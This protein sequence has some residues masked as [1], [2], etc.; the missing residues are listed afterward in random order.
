MRRNETSPQQPP[1]RRMRGRR[2][3]M[4]V[5]F[6]IAGLA[7]CMPDAPTSVT[8]I[9]QIEETLARKTG[10]MQLN[11]VLPAMGPV[12]EET[13]VLLRGTG[14]TDGM[15]VHFGDQEAAAVQVID[16]NRATAQVPQNG[17]GAVDV[18]IAGDHG[19]AVAPDGFTWFL[20]GPEDGTDTDGDGLTD[21]QELKGWTIKV[22]VLGWGLDSGHVTNVSIPTPIWADTPSGDIVVVYTARSDI[23]NPDT[24]GDG[25]GDLDEF[26]VRADPVLRDT[27]S[28]GLWDG[29]E[30]FRW[31]TSPVS[32]DT[33]GDARSPDVS[34]TFATLPPNPSLFD[35]AELY[36]SSQLALEP[37]ARGQIKLNATSPTLDDTDGDSVRDTDEIDT[38][39]RVPWLADMPQLRFEIVDDIDVRLDVEYA[40]EVGTTTAFETS[41]AIGQSRTLSQ[42]QSNTVS[43]SVTVGGEVNFS[44]TELGGSA[45]VE[46]TAGFEQ[47]FETTRESSISAERTFTELQE[48]SRTNTET[49]ATGSINTGVRISN[50]G[51]I[52][53]QLIDM[54]H[55][56]RQWQPNPN[57][58]LVDM[59]PGSY[60]TLAALAPDLGPGLTLAPGADSGVLLA[61]ATDLNPDR[62]RALL[63][64]PDALQIEPVAFEL[65]NEQGINF[66]FI[67]EVT[68][69][70]TARISIDYGDG[71]FEEFRVATN[72]D[73]NAD[74][75]Y[76]GITLARALDMT[77]GASN[78]ETVTTIDP[79]SGIPQELIFNGSFELPD[80]DQGQG[81]APTG[82]TVRFPDGVDE[83]Q[84]IFV[85]ER[86]SPPAP[87]GD[88]WARMVL[89]TTSNP[90]SRVAM[91][92]QIGTAQ[93]EAMS[94]D[95]TH[96]VRWLGTPSD[97]QEF[98]YDVS[99]WQGEPGT[100]GATQL[101]SD[102]HI[103]GDSPAATQVSG[104]LGYAAQMVTPG[105][106]IYIEVLGY[107]ATA[108]SIGASLLFDGFDVT[109]DVP[110]IDVISRVR[111]A[112]YDLDTPQFWAIFLS[113]E[114]ASAA[115][116]LTNVVLKA[117]DT[118]LL[119]L[120]RDN[121]SDGLFAAQEQQYGSSDE[122]AD[123][124]GDGLTD[125]E[126][127][128]RVY[129]NGLCDTAFGGWNVEVTDR[130]GVMSTYRVYSDPRVVDSDNDNVT[131][132]Q[133]KAR[134]T[135]PNLADTD[136]DN[137][138][139]D[140]DPQPTIAARTL[141]VK[142]DGDDG[143][144]GLTWTTALLTVSAAIN[145]AGTLNTDGVPGNDI[146]EI[147]VAQGTYGLTNAQFPH[148]VVMSG[149]F[150]GNETRRGQRAAG[151][152]TNE[153]FLDSANGSPVFDHTGNGITAFVDGFTFQGSNNRAIRYN[154]TGATTVT[155][156]NC[157]FIGNTAIIN[158]V[159]TI[160]GAAGGAIRAFGPEG[161]LVMEDCVLS[162]NRVFT[163]AATPT[164]GLG[165][166]IY[167][168]M[169][170]E[171]R[172]CSFI[173]NSVVARTNNNWH[174]GGA[175]HLGTGGAFGP[176]AVI[177]SCIFR[178][179]RIVNDVE[180][181]IGGNF[182]HGGALSVFTSVARANVN[183]C[184]FEGN[185]VDD[186]RE[187]FPGPWTST[188]AGGA[189]VI[190][191]GQANFLN[192]VFKNNRAP[193]FGG[194][195]YT[196]DDGDARLV[197]C[198][199]FANVADPNGNPAAADRGVNNPFFTLTP[200]AIGAAVG[201]EGN[202]SLVNCAVWDNTGTEI[203]QIGI[204]GAPPL[205]API[206]IKTWGSETQVAVRPRIFWI[207]T[208]RLES[209]GSVFVDNCA[210]NTLSGAVLANI[211]GPSEVNFIPRIVAAGSFGVGNIA[212]S[213][214]GF[215]DLATGNLRLSSSSP[216]IDA[217][218]T[219]VDADRNLS[220]FQLLPDFDF[221]GNSR[222]VDG[223]GD[224]EARVDI[225]AYEALRDS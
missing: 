132:D 195:V 118:A 160:S 100:P 71:T 10:T 72:I 110:M 74:S 16:E 59:D 224:G 147:W 43:A 145:T 183:D 53:V 105:E 2:A 45:S 14:F 204:I 121:D 41:L 3:V 177:D 32:V 88:Q 117:G 166:A 23:N 70:R 57:A 143:N 25:L 78:W 96:L 135:D 154:V 104:S 13:I 75:T 131:D 159:D 112:S 49:A 9:D 216:L 90:P 136:N 97:P 120:T 83:T 202:T 91:Y 206:T 125:G 158:G 192:C 152:L 15:T 18:R 116:G 95:Y 98:T 24:D 63:S 86:T 35:G 203:S 191:D 172:R 196:T 150:A 157:F 22:D 55:T 67:D 205:T 111:H 33:D 34:S 146:S 144:D 115:G 99:L 77:V 214:P 167:T 133:E 58:D 219:V 119:S 93:S 142:M 164:R 87:V 197:N 201:S 21:H 221:D 109:P 137:L 181:G 31:L 140:I 218:E 64:R 48:R 5:P 163:S 73:R 185:E 19:D 101:I 107:G 4:L 148:L 225:G 123:S 124:D 156:T 17:S 199:L 215:V 171:L 141:H 36:T 178:A 46:V 198:T 220:G 222:I 106:P 7:G 56:I 200:L 176:T 27:D 186:A 149:G 211:V 194:A 153:T 81:G 20:L 39:V 138:P 134:R 179:N 130:A 175:V 1:R 190:F 184:I 128:A 165:G 54:V 187:F 126:E 68:Q 38:P 212:P 85:E 103:I 12:D 170:I 66:A 102:Q 127:A 8:D 161:L 60:Q 40:E 37:S 209:I 89:G 76:K 11:S 62:V 26:F 69:A 29:E 28:D 189:A 30:W 6:V 213:N 113:G 94:Y 108:P 79:C 188:R 208:V 114:Q 44:P 129:R 84:D 193:M 51:N 80:N 47:S 174:M 92:Q 65:I 217:G 168:T 122:S 182:I 223:N 42:S 180:A 52:T 139:D 169:D 82:W 207:G 210:L 50:V 162:D 151:A 61:E 173:G 155:L